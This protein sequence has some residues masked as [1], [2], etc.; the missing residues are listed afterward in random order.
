MRRCI[1]DIGVFIGLTM[2]I[3]TVSCVTK[4]QNA[5]SVV[6][7]RE[8]LLQ[9][10]TETGQADSSTMS[11]LPQVMVFV[12]NQSYMNK[13]LENVRHKLQHECYIAFRDFR[14]RPTKYI[15]S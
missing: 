12:D 11:D 6:G 1:S 15:F 13:V 9:E 7:T 2:F 8:A 14:K 3:L 5:S 4:D 10:N